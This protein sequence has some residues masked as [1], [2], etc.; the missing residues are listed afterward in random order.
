MTDRSGTTPVMTSGRLTLWSGPETVDKVLSRPVTL[1]GDDGDNT[2]IGTRGDN[3]QVLIGGGGLDRLY[4]GS[5]DGPFPTSTTFLITKTSDLVVGE[6]Y[7]GVRF[8]NGFEYDHTSILGTDIKADVSLVGI[9]MTDVQVI[10]GIYG[11]V[12]M[13]TGQLAGL[14]VVQAGAIR[15]AG[16]GTVQLAD[17]VDAADLFLADTATTVTFAAADVLH[18]QG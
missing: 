2:L 7:Q 10:K 3:A 11:M 5:N 18:L 6:V 13:T 16:G 15:L 9:T 14:D 17:F 4:A 8:Q 1:R 12:T